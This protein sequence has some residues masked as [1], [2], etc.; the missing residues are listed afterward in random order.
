MIPQRSLALALL[1]ISALSVFVVSASR[2]AGFDRCLA[3][4]LE[5]IFD[6]FK[7]VAAACTVLGFHHMFVQSTLAWT[8]C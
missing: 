2:R 6:F 5:Q 8:S 1:I 7:S 4:L 3:V